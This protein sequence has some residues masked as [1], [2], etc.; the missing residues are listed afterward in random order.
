MRIKKNGILNEKIKMIILLVAGVSLFICALEGVGF[1]F[2]LMFKE[3]AQFFLSMVESDMAPYAGLA[4]GVIATTLLE[5]S[6]AVVATTMMSM[7][8]M[9][10]SGLHLASAIRF[11]IPMVMGA[12][13]GTT[14]G[15]TITLFAIRRSTTREEFDRSIDPQARFL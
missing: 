15:N 1:G 3:Y 13:V 14:V 4:I 10:E 9:V 7:A 8:G 11:G 5:S 6:S 12:N 2:K